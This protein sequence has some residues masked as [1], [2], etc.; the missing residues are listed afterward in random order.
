MTPWLWLTSLAFNTPVGP[1]IGRPRAAKPVAPSPSPR[2]TPAPARPRALPVVAPAAGERRTL[3]DDRALLARL[4][5]GDEAAFAA[6]VEA[7]SGP[8]LRL[9]RAF[10]A[11]QAVAEEVL[12]ETW[13]AVLRGLPRFEGRSSLRTWLFRILTNRAKTRGIRE[14]RTVPFTSLGP[15]E[16]PEME[17]ARFEFDGNHWRQPPRSSEADTPERLALLAE[18]RRLVEAAVEELPDK[19]R[20]VITLRDL[21]LCSSEEVCNILDIAETYQRVLLHRARTRIRGVVA[22]YLRGDAD[23]DLPTSER[24][25][26]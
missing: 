9:A 22:A 1:A 21:E 15:A 20:A 19:Q 13:M 23:A 7:Y 26:D 16:T 10:V 11:S 12:Q 6:M 2:P 25:G 5:A 24:A 4:L 3:P 14:G 8:M 18:V 17:P